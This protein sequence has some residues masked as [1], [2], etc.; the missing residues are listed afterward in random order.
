MVRN[1]D[2]MSAF[3]VIMSLWNLLGFVQCLI[4]Q[5]GEFATI[6]VAILTSVVIIFLPLSRG[7]KRWTVAVSTILGITAAILA[8]GGIVVSG[9]YLGTGGFL[10]LGIL[11]AVFGLRAYREEPSSAKLL[12]TS[13]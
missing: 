6:P 8:I 4:Q 12:A 5:E 2:L 13:S 1:I 10:V 9:E 3:M 7:G 11:I